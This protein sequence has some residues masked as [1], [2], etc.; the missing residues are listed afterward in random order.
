LNTPDLPESRISW[1]YRIPVIKNIFLWYDIL[2]LYAIVYVVCVALLA[3]IFLVSGDAA[4]IGPIARIFAW[5]CGGLAAASLVIAFIW[6]ANRIRVR[7]TMSAKGVLYET[8]ERKDVRANR[9]LI[10]FGLLTGKPGAA[11]TG[12][13][14]ASRETELIPWRD[15]KKAKMHPAH[16]VISLMSRWRVLTRLYCPP[17]RYGEIAAYA[18]GR[19]GRT[20]GEIPGS[21][22]DAP[23]A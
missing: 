17:E 21:G 10:L 8:L 19:I 2:K 14:A 16:G 20:G 6:Y 9:L 13:I 23:A 7:F 1:E 3:T 18:A 4:G 12:L 22:K 5:V 15:V 11:G